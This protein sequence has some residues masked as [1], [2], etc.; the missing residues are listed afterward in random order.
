MKI[1][2]IIKLE[3]LRLFFHN[4]LRAHSGFR[5]PRQQQ[6]PLRSSCPGQAKF[7]LV[8]LKNQPTVYM[9]N[10]NSP[11]PPPHLA[12]T[13]RVTM[14]G[15][16][17]LSHIN[18][19]SKIGFLNP[20]SRIPHPTTSFGFIP[21]VSKSLSRPLLV[22]FPKG[23]LLFQSRIPPTISELSCIP[24]IKMSA[25]RSH[26]DIFIPYPNLSIS[27]IPHPAL[28]LFPIL[29]PTKPMLDPLLNGG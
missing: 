2:L 16:T 12:L 15:G 14:V 8:S 23:Y 26:Q 5:Y 3:F 21:P 10:V 28:I 25:S 19:L 29:H 13:G 24:P 6:K 17:T 18:T 27:R 9:R 7:S 22:K 11:P 4:R 20:A 1:S